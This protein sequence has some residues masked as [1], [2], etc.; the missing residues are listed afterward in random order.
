MVN[1]QISNFHMM[2]FCASLSSLLFFTFSFR[3]TSLNV[4]SCTAWASIEYFPGGFDTNSSSKLHLRA[5][6]SQQFP[7]FDKRRARLQLLPYVVWKIQRYFHRGESSSACC[8][9][10]RYSWCRKNVSFSYHSHSLRHFIPGVLQHFLFSSFPFDSASAFL[11]TCPI[12]ISGR[13][14]T[15][16]FFVLTLFRPSL[17]SDICN[18]RPEIILTAWQLFP[19]TLVENGSW[20]I[21][22]KP[23][24]LQL[25]SV[26]RSG[27]PI[28][29][30]QCQ[31]KAKDFIGAD[32]VYVR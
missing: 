12:T 20:K 18:H 11:M 15:S 21:E 10:T 13:Y 3:S 6:G 9:I 14:T 7:I 1:E 28:R 17:A 8:D 32:C 5:S 25:T 4:F 27:S 26:G 31:C 19:L 29:F 22:N 30:M 2:I 24:A 16:S 23:A